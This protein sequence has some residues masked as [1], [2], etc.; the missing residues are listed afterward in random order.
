MDELAT[1]SVDLLT[2]ISNG[3][4]I[5]AGLDLVE[6]GGFSYSSYPRAG[7]GKLQ[8]V[9]DHGPTQFPEVRQAIAYLLDR[10]DFA[11]SFTGGFGS[12]VHGPTEKLSGSIRKQKL[13]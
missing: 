8:F 4:E 9:C 13:N 10:N 12:V 11:K 1:G 3:A 5:Q 2:G 7:Y 6:Q